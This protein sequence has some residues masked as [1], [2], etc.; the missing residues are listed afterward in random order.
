MYY[1]N[2]YGSE[3]SLCEYIQ[4]SGTEFLIQYRNGLKVLLC[5]KYNEGIG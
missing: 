4:S 2:Y 3:D 5:L 1:V